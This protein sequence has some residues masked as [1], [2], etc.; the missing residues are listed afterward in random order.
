MAHEFMALAHGIHEPK[1]I[2]GRRGSTLGS[3]CP[4]SQSFDVLSHSR[5][6]SGTR[7]GQFADFVILHADHACA[8]I[9]L[10]LQSLLGGHSNTSNECLRC[11]KPR[12]SQIP[13]TKPANAPSTGLL[14]RNRNKRARDQ[15][16][17][18]LLNYLSWLYTVTLW[19][20]YRM[21]VCATQ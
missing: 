15:H 2:L 7:S 9:I 5:A 4:L 11:L 12:Q 19:I 13:Q 21:Y 3:P 18:I 8:R 10:A 16:P 20:I 17:Q 1:M 6:L 14:K